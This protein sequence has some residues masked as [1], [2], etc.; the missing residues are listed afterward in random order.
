MNKN[1][2]GKKGV[3]QNKTKKWSSLVKNDRGSVFN[4]ASLD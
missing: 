3:K 1:Q 2:R 4:H